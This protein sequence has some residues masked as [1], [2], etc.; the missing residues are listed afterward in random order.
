[1]PEKTLP[2]E[3]DHEC[4]TLKLFWH[5]C[6]GMKH[7]F[8]QIQLQM[9]ISHAKNWKCETLGYTK[10][11]ENVLPFCFACTQPSDDILHFAH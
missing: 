7:D 11:V 6:L 4:D 2:K 3:T 5:L 8:K 9:Q 10:I 1:M